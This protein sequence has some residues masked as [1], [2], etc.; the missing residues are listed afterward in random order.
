MFATAGLI[1]A[2]ALRGGEAP[3]RWYV[4]PSVV[5]AGPDR[6]GPGAAD[7]AL[8]PDERGTV[9]A[10][11]VTALSRVDGVSAV[12]VDRAGYAQ[13]GPATEA[14]PWAASALHPGTL[15]TGSPPSDAEQVVLTAPTEARVGQVVTVATTDG[16]QR[17][18]VSGILESPAIP[19]LYVSDALAARLSHHRIVAIALVPRPSVDPAA[20]AA[21]VR[22]ALPGYPRLRVLT[23]DDRRGAEFDAEA[24]LYIAAT[25]LT[26]SIAGLAGFVTVYIVA[27]TF[28][29]T[30]TQRRR[31]LALLRATGATPGQVRRLVLSEAVLVGASGGLAG[32]VLGVSGASAAA[33][34]LAGHG[35]APDGFTTALVWWP[36][37]AAYLVG[38][39]VAVAGAGWAARRAGR[40]RPVEAIGEAMVERRGAARDVVR[41]V[42]GAVCLAGAV[43]VSRL[44]SGPAGAAY[45][46]IVVILLILGTTLLLPVLMRPVNRLATIGRGP[47]ALLARASARF[48][49]RRYASG[50][51]P[52][53]VT[54]GLAGGTL[55]GTT[56]ISAAEAAD[57]RHQVT[58]SLMVVPAG[59]ARLPSESANR[60][61]DLPGVAAAAPVKATSVF[62]EVDDAAREHTAWFVDGA[63]LPDVLRV[64]VASGSFDDLVDGAAGVSASMAAAHS[65]RVGQNVALGMGDG[66]T[67]QLRIAAVVEDR[68][69]LPEVFL[70][71]DLARAHSA[72]PVPDTVYLAL[73]PNAGR[74]AVGAAA[75]PLGTVVTVKSHLVTLDEEFDRLNRLSLLALLGVALVYTAVAVA[76][77]Q[78]VAVSDRAG[79]LRALRRIGATR[80]QVIS[81][82]RREGLTVIVTGTAFG[83]GLTAS[84]LIAVHVALSPVS[85]AVR[86]SAPWS[87]IFAVVA[88]CAAITLAVGSVS[89]RR[90]LRAG[91][92]GGAE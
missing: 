71:W 17:L 47:I 63:A 81:L 42:S 57:L 61:R 34:W 15:V 77:T 60:L 18:T 26:G 8:P 64:P 6:A 88:S 62:D 73:K 10:D 54:I 1:F 53:L 45:L 27:G 56:T 9:P 70:S 32:I 82:V 72:T 69:G 78:L 22:S 4:A 59:A 14:H 13:F 7:P 20:L 55:A 28:L 41:W 16:P 35:L 39:L 19:A 90:V 66:G 80:R 30:V 84:T 23:G 91:Q 29:F 31:E 76:N 86:T 2:A 67:A 40:I 48:E 65:W 46:L 51:A 11:V 5:V 50:I 49:P 33:A 68:L 44:M 36:L 38:L 12:V 79:E 25:S 83:L 21:E 87:V 75:A 37:V 43:A 74:D 58:A 89:A 3:P 92:R 24:G 52:V 85:D